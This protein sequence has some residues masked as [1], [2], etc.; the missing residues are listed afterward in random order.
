VLQYLEALRDEAPTLSEDAT[1]EQLQEQ[2]YAK[3]TQGKREEAIAVKLELADGLAAEETARMARGDSM[4]PVHNSPLLGTPRSMDAW[5]GGT[6][7]E[8][9]RDIKEYIEGEL[10]DVPEPT[11]LEAGGTGRN[12]AGQFA[13]GFFVRT[14]GANL[15]DTDAA[16]FSP[17]EIQEHDM[18]NSHAVVTGNM[19]TDEVKAE[20]VAQNDGKKFDV[21]FERLFV[22][23]ETVP[24]E[25]FYVAQQAA[26]YYD[27]LSDNG[28]MFAQVMPAHA[29]MIA[30]WKTE[31]DNNY[32]GLE[33]EIDTVLGTY[34]VVRIQKREGAPAH[35]PLFHARSI[36]R[37]QRESRLN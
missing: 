12:L 3:S 23:Q 11:L 6:L 15:T 34:P 14:I 5:F 29:D 27:M 16:D 19:L 2:R 24:N 7:P 18:V 9:S 20:L 1:P 32:P 17:Q 30:A 25:P 28:I 21:I 4:W 31:V 37:W 26:D 33:V 35:L 22:G 13:E 36:I 10:A 8:G